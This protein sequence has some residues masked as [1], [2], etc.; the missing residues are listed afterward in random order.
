[1]ITKYIV[2][3]RYVPT[4]QDFIECSDY[5]KSEIKCKLNAEENDI[6]KSIR[7]IFGLKNIPLKHIQLK[8]YVRWQKN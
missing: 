7:K 1:M 6:K 3:W 8:S 4:I 5:T 2:E